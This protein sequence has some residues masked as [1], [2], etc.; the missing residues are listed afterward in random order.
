AW[1]DAGP[2][3][4]ARFIRRLSAEGA[5]FADAPAR[6]GPDTPLLN[7]V[8]H[9]TWMVELCDGLDADPGFAQAPTWRGAPAETG[10]LARQRSDPLI[11]GLKPGPANRVLLRYV[12]RL[13]ELAGLLTGHSPAVA[14]AQALPGGGAV[15]WVENTRGL[16]IHQARFEAGRARVYRIVAPTAWNF[17][18]Q[19]ELAGALLGVPARDLTAVKQWARHVVH[20]LDPCVACRV[21]IDDA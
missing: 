15:A 10:A 1:A 3:V 17:H 12:A 21:E 8:H 2:T 16:L 18:P 11:A 14:G 9:Q 6:P 13:R 20:S 5:W 7:A 19:G 4:A